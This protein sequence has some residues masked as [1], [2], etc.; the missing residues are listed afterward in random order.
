ME[1]K[2]Y[3]NELPTEDGQYI[4]WAARPFVAW[5]NATGQIWELKHGINIRADSGAITHWCKVEAPKG[6]I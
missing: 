6:V 4:V 2:Y 3:K 5:Y 1:W